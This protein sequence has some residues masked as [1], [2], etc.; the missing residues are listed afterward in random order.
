[1]PW[2]F[3]NPDNKPTKIVRGSTMKWCSKD[4]HEKPMWCGR[5][6]C[7]DRADFTDAW[8]KKKA[9]V[10][11]STGSDSNSDFKIALAAMTSPEDFAALQDQFESLKD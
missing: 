4:C 1:M 11:S 3:E 10:D 6:N 9:A 5:R 8:K 2:R 7:L